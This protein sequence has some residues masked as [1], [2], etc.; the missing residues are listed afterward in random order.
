MALAA[1]SQKSPFDGDA[2]KAIIADTRKGQWMKRPAFL[3]NFESFQPASLGMGVLCAW[4]Y[5]SFFTATFAPQDLHELSLFNSYW[6]FFNLGAFVGFGFFIFS[7][8]RLGELALNSHT[9]LAAALLMVFGT[10]LMALGSNSTQ[11]QLIIGGCVGSGVAGL[12]SV[13]LLIAWGSAFRSVSAGQAE[14]VIP[15]NILISMIITAFMCLTAGWLSIALAAIFPLLSLV[16]LRR[17]IR[18]SAKSQNES[19]A[20]SRPAGNQASKP[21]VWKLLLLIVVFWV[22]FTVSRDYALTSILESLWMFL[23]VFS[24][25]VAA[26]AITV[27]VY[28]FFS[29][30]VSSHS[31]LQI[32][33]PLS[34]ASLL[35]API[36]GER[37][38]VLIFILSFVA[39]TS[40]DSYAWITAVSLT[41]EDRLTCT[42]GIGRLRFAVQAGGFIGVILML[43]LPEAP[44]SMAFTL[45]A[46]A[47]ITTAM[48][49]LGASE[50]GGPS[51]ENDAKTIGYPARNEPDT[52]CIAIGAQHGLSRR[53]QEVLVFLVRGRDVP[54]IRETLFISRNT[55]NTHIKHIYNK[56]GIHSKQELFDLVEKMTG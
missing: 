17:F 12:G 46:L 34:C 53:E 9:Q 20:V 54:Y 23:A 45:I 36:A 16:L 19:K 21:R 35:L 40:F 39:L 47:L 13:P 18:R 14:I 50:T 7:E 10:L 31:I 33:L 5:S 51:S 49:A 41:R 25:G 22:A 24:I 48:A 15:L 38:S 44:M 4:I 6:L 30:K 3:L 42:A 52:T 29:R 27:I 56:L 43:L 11:Q 32:V 8:R 28:L 26:A 1:N 55:V 37:F 2:A